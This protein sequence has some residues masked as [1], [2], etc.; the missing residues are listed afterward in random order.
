MPNFSMNYATLGI[1][2]KDVAVVFTVAVIGLQQQ[3]QGASQLCAQYSRAHVHRETQT[4]SK[5]YSSSSA[6]HASFD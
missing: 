5:D 1:K 4:G 6:F 3:M 2:V